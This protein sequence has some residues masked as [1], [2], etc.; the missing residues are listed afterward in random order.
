MGSAPD[1]RPTPVLRLG[2]E[3]VRADVLVLCAEEHQPP[4]KLWPSVEVVVYCPMDDAELD[5]KTLRR[6]QRAAKIV[7]KCVRAGARVLVTCWAG[8][9]RSGLVTALA[10][11]EL[12]G[13]PGR[14]VLRHI[15]RKRSGALTNPSF[16]TYLERL[17]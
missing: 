6:A 10:L 16:V 3:G 8:R 12:T 13:W 2:R 17:P 4:A 1:E 15:Q 11:R 5:R 14:Q 9:N 7:V